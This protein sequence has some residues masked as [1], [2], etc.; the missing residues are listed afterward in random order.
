MSGKTD[1]DRSGAIV[2]LPFDGATIRTS[3]A[4]PGKDGGVGQADKANPAK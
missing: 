4:R 3:L 1:V 2:D